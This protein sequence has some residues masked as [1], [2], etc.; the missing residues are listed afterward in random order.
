MGVF[1]SDFGD[2]VKVFFWLFLFAFVG[3]CSVSIYKN[4]QMEVYQYQMHIK[5]ADSIK[6]PVGECSRLFKGER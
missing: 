4:H 5:C 6:I 3:G 1:M 2:F